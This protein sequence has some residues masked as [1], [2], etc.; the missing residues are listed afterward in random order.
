MALH[1][2][3]RSCLQIA[4]EFHGKPP[5]APACESVQ[6]PYVLHLGCLERANGLDESRT[7]NRIRGL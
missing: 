3:H 1:Q 4:I 5:R 7:G 6:S 2:H